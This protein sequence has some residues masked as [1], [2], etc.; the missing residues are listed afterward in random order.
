[1]WIYMKDDIEIK[2]GGWDGPIVIEELR[3]EMRRP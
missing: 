1:M 2:I 3:V